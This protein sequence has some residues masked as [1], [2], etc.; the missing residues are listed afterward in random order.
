MSELRSASA[1]WV[2]AD[3]L[4]LLLAVRHSGLVKQFYTMLQSLWSS[5]SFTQFT[6]C[7]V[8]ALNPHKIKGEVI[9]GKL[10]ATMWHHLH[11]L[12]I[13]PLGDATCPVT[14]LRIALVASSVGIELISTGVT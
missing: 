7:K 1:D 6:P 13:W 3:E 10:L 9:L 11:W 12:K 8:F 14:L 4:I 2:C 5:T